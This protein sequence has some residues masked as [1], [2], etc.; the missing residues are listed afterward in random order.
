MKDNII[1]DNNCIEIRESK[2]IAVDRPGESAGNSRFKRQVKMP[3]ASPICRSEYFPSRAVAFYSKALTP[4][5]C[6]T[7]GCSD[8]ALSLSL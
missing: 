7:V 8:I 1:L 4:L 6:K 2:L 5:D 3:R